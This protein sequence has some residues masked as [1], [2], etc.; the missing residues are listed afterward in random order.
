MT[1]PHSAQRKCVFLVKIKEKSKSQ[2]QIPKKK[3][4]LGLLIQRLGYISTE[5][6]IA[7]DTD[8]KMQTE[9]ADE[10]D[11]TVCGDSSKV[12]GGNLHPHRK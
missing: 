10:V 7:V 12:W 9:Y 2:K 4:Y 11:V 5:S 1:L 8:R 3:V 6:L